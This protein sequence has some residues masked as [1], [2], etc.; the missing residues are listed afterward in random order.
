MSEP[1]SCP[2][3]NGSG[4]YQGLNTVEP[5]RACGG[6]KSMGDFARAVM[7]AETGGSVDSR[8][9]ETENPST[10]GQ[11]LE[12]VKT[13]TIADVCQQFAIPEIHFTVTP[14]SSMEFIADFQSIDHGYRI[15]HVPTGYRTLYIRRA[16]YQKH[17]IREIAQ[18]VVN[19][20]RVNLVCQLPDGSDIK[21]TGT[22]QDFQCYPEVQE[23]D[24]TI[25]QGPAD[26]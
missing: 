3:C 18:A 12:D 13:H 20:E 2:E 14:T 16:I 11:F 6:F 7:Q 22:I 10:T 21:A 8:L 19:R 17:Q 9:K 4:V 5:C 23:L 25:E 15:E 1:Y 24:I 26:A